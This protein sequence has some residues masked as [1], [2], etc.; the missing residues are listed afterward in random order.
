MGQKSD[1]DVEDFGPLELPV[2]VCRGFPRDAAGPS[3]KSEREGAERT[4]EPGVQAEDHKCLT[5]DDIEELENDF[6]AIGR[7]ARSHRE[8][9]QKVAE[10]GFGATHSAAGDGHLLWAALRATALQSR[11]RLAMYGIGLAVLWFVVSSVWPV[12]WSRHSCLDDASRRATDAG[13]RVAL[14][15]CDEK[16]PRR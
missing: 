12:E 2:H 8:L 9:Q 14:M 5:D 15:A 6:P 4:G 10:L 7:L 3:Q 16:F 13:V 11:R 1:R